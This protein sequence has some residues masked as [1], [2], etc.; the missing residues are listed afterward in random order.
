L[1]LD[2]LLLWLTVTDAD[3][4]FMLLDDDDDDDK[5]LTDTAGVR[6]VVEI[7][8]TNGTKTTSCNL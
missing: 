6:R 1:L 5:S 4:L 2:I 7:L 3:F 8:P